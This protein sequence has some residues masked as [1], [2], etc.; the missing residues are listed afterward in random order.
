MVLLNTMMGRMVSD[1]QRDWDLCVPYV[2]AAYRATVHQSTGYRPNYL[3]FAR[4]VRSPVDLVFGTPLDQSPTSYDDYSMAV[5]ERMKQAYS[6]VRQ[7]L[8]TAA[9]RLKRQY[10]V[11]VGQQQY[12][13][14]QWVLYYN[15][16]KYQGRQQ[17]W[18]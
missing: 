1:Q 18:Q 6:L 16:R 9:Q 4:E 2:M 7:H 15:P 11:R 3:M 14:G 17:K 5:E 10:D 13:K 12:R 8:G